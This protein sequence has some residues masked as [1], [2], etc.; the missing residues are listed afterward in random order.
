MTNCIMLEDAIKNSGYTIQYI[1]KRLG[2]TP[3]AFYNKRKGIRDFT[4]EEMV[5]LCDILGISNSK[6]E[7]I[8]LS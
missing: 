1:A 5:K 6:R 4:V 8:F 7:K 3:A 2:I